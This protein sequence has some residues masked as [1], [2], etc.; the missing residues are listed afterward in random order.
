[1]SNRKYIAIQVQMVERD[2]FLILSVMHSHTCSGNTK[3]TVIKN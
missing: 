2:F 3:V 1:M